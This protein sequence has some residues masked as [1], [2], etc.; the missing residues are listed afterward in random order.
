M[1]TRHQLYQSILPPEG[2]ILKE[3]VKHLKP[4]T[5]FE[6]GTCNG[7]ATGWMV[8]GLKGLTWR[9]PCGFDAKYLKPTID[10][11][12]FIKHDLSENVEE[13]IAEVR[14]HHEPAVVLLKR[15]LAA[16]E[17]AFLDGA[18]ENEAL[19]RELVL[20][21]V[22]E[23]NPPTVFLH[24]IRPGSGDPLNSP[25]LGLVGFLALTGCQSKFYRVFPGSLATNMDIEELK[26]LDGI[27]GVK[28]IRI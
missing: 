4:R 26:R 28:E 5:V 1:K 25:Y 11:C 12:D 2:L 19:Y 20:L 14:F 10:C 6:S 16:Y 18:H 7:Y 23:P 27:E 13:N 21:G 15:R 3:A 17:F 9:E 22:H 8:Q 24:D